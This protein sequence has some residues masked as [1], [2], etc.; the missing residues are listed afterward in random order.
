MIGRIFDVLH[1][2]RLPSAA[3]FMGYPT[4]ELALQGDKSQSPYFQ[5]L[6]G[7]WKFH[8]V[9]RSDERPMDFF[10]KGYDVSGWD[11]I[12]VSS[13]WELQ[14]FGYPFYVGSGYGIK[15]N[16][17]LIAVENSPVGSYRRTFTIPAHWNKRQIILYF[18]GV[19]S[20]FYVWVNGEKVG[21]SQ[22]SKT[23]S[24]FDITPYVKQG[25]NEI[26]V[27]VFKFSDGYYLEDQDYWRLHGLFRSVELA[28]QPR[29]HVETVQIEAG[30][31]PSTA[32][33]TLNATLQLR[34]ANDAA[35]VK[36]KLR[37]AS[38]TVVWE[39]TQCANETI[40]LN[41]RCAEEH[42]AVERRR[43]NPV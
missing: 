26:A 12:K 21:Y 1:I 19:A 33:G 34:N 38:G 8:F 16:P 32:A 36:A 13:N 43:A 17:P 11:D 39:S 30:Y 35:T 5:S 10:Q 37:D 4:K 29:V 3:N 2:N 28:A 25:E 15:K 6:N 41:S 27:Q 24:E 22:D 7:T 31:N 40:I 9:P 20:A 14:G 42:R 23:P 18:G